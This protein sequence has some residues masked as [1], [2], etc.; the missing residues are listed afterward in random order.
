ME[1]RS[2]VL[3]GSLHRD[4]RRILQL[5]GIRTSRINFPGEPLKTRQRVFVR[6]HRLM[7]SVRACVRLLWIF[8]PLRLPIIP[9]LPPHLP[10]AGPAVMFLP[11]R[12]RPRG[13]MQLRRVFQVRRQRKLAAPNLGIL[14]QLIRRWAR[15]LHL[16]EGRARRLGRAMRLRRTRGELQGIR[17]RILSIPRTPWDICQMVDLRVRRE[18]SR[19]LRLSFWEWLF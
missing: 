10:G 8:A 9:L 19:S 12:P 5:R 6:C 7:R 1:M 11:A 2:P 14:P 17:L 16:G 18:S 4:L 15:R 3:V 13:S